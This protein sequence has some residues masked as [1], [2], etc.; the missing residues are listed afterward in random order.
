MGAIL[1]LVGL[2]VTA[3]ID[4]QVS[5][6][7][8]FHVC[9]GFHHPCFQDLVFFRSRE[10]YCVVILEGKNLTSVRYLS[11]VFFLSVFGRCFA[12]D[13]SS[14][15]CHHLHFL[16]VTLSQIRH[17]LG[18]PALPFGRKIISLCGLQSVH[19]GS[20][21]H[22]SSKASPFSFLQ[23]VVWNYKVFSGNFEQVLRG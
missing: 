14:H 16:S 13:R 4:C 19:G 18:P 12:I 15:V 11:L 20:T 1:S 22:S 8:C 17:L 7:P 23:Q 5:I 2:N 9:P 6:V 3:Q 21:L 10:P